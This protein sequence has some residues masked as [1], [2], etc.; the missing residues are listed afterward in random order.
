[1]NRLQPAPLLRFSFRLDGVAS[2]IAGIATTLGLGTAA[3]WLGMPTPVALALGLFMAAY[4]ALVFWLGG[5]HRLGRALVL[6]IAGGN[7]LWVAASL[8]LLASDLIDPTRTGVAVIVGQAAAVAVFSL[9][10]FAGYG[11]SGPVAA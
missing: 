8:A 10:Q 5:R 3:I 11:R 4:G 6:G 7:A 1:M 9:L 2:A